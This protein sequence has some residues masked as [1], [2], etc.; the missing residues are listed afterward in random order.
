LN[1][2]LIIL[3]ADPARGGAERYT[4][5][6]AAALA[7]DGHNVSLLAC[8]FASAAQSVRC[9]EIKAT[10]VTRLGR[11][12][13]FLDSLDAHLATEKYDITHAMLPVRHCDIYHPHAG[14]AA[15]TITQG[16]RAS[17]LGNRFNL[18]RHRFAAV[19]RQ[20]LG[21]LNPPIAL[22]LSDYVRTSLLQFYPLPPDQTATLFNAIDLDRFDCRDHIGGAGAL[23]IAQDFERKG[24]RQA[25][26]ALAKVP[27]CRLMVVGNDDARAYQTHAASVGVSDRVQFAG[28]TDD[29]R[30][31][32]RAADFFV[33]PT[34]HDPC[35]LV[36]LESL[37]MGVPVI[38][39]KFNG[40][41]EIMAD[42]V[43]GYV[44]PDPM[45]VNAL[46][47]AMEK[48]MDPTRRAAMS[49]A[50]IGLRPALAYQEHVRKLIA[51]YQR[52]IKLALPFSRAPEA[53]PH[54]GG[55]RDG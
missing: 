27:A 15:Q 36:V 31:F 2:A 28:P 26:S 42:G 3:H 33:L 11:Y 14:I 22:C 53:C 51:I 9:V 7:Q 29:P 54:A 23:M 5:D 25:I 47:A 37:A 13:H 43:H 10:G 34:R 18:R 30:R 1:I 17:R 55:K 45:D 12:V 49:H 52:K 20:L 39:T 48:M 41:C 38:S 16:S 46:A 40:A 6:L 32:Y 50:C 8:A 24:L 19:E 4:H 35:S 44:L 21:S